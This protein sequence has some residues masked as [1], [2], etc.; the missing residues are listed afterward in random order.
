MADAAGDVTAFYRQL[1][2][3][4]PRLADDAILVVQADGKL[5]ITG[6]FTQLNGQSRGGYARLNLN[7]S[8]D[9]SFTQGTSF[10]V[11]VPLTILPDG[12]LLAGGARY[13]TGGA[14]EVAA[15]E[16][17]FTLVGGGLQLTWPVGFQLQRTLSLS[18]ADWQSV[19]NPSPFTVPPATT[20]LAWSGRVNR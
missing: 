9:A 1:V 7:G 16:L 14:V 4:S 3:P 18:P 13:F 8:T 19:A 12:K 17:D 11:G 2:S 6:Q 15:P 5:I 20:P 10:G